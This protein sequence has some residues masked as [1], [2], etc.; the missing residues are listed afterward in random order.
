VVNP[1]D[2]IPTGEFNPHNV[3]PWLIHN[4]YGTLA[5]VY[6]SH[7]QDALDEAVDGDKMDSCMVSP[8]DYAEAEREGHADEY[9]N[10]GNAGEPFDLTYIGM[11]PLPNKQYGVP[12]AEQDSEIAEEAKAQDEH[13][14]SEKTAG[15]E[16][17][18]AQS[19]AAY[20]NHPVVAMLWD[21]LKR[22]PEHKD[23]RMTA[24]GTKTKQGLVLSVERA[25]KDAGAK[26][27]AE[28]A[29]CK[30]CKKN[31]A[32]KNDPRCKSCMDSQHSEAERATG[33]Q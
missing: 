30:V 13:Q 3:R 33:V 29:K 6:A 14:S 5:I 17:N 31:P 24:W 15:P 23:R 16:N 28:G 25:I 11:I 4:E 12:T 27:G 18:P 1:D 7:E 21:Y 22:D 19:D 10:L 9:A 8:E 32:Q 20:E 26:T 2:Y